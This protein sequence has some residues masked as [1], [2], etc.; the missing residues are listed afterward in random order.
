MQFLPSKRRALLSIR[1]CAFIRINM[2]AVVYMANDC[3]ILIICLVTLGMEF[4]ENI[5]SSEKSLFDLKRYL[6]MFNN[7]FAQLCI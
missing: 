4:T 6:Y 7:K 2:Q 1:H 3:H 5:P